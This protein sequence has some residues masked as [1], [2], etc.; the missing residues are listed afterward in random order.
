MAAPVL[1]T[2]HLPTPGRLVPLATATTPAI[3]HAFCA[4]VYEEYV[5]RERTAVDE[6]EAAVYRAELRRLREVFI[7]IGAE[8]WLFAGEALETRI[9]S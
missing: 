2:L 5:R 8:T 3:I 4:G 9:Q 1:L 6:V 7:L